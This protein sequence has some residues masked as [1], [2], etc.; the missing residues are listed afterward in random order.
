MS[1]HS[2]TPLQSA[3]RTPRSAAAILASGAIALVLCCPPLG[4]TAGAAVAQP[5][6]THLTAPA[7][8]ILAKDDG[9]IGPA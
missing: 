1:P 5:L 2:T 3:T 8:A 6:G 9:N 7:T 4:G